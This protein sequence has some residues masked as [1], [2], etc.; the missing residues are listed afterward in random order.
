MAACVRNHAQSWSSGSGLL[1]G[2]RINFCCFWSP[3]HPPPV[4]VCYGG[5]GESCRGEL[6]D[7]TSLQIAPGLSLCREPGLLTMLPR[8]VQA[9]RF[10]FVALTVGRP[11]EWILG[12]SSGD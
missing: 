1:N 7:H 10:V 3:P 4:V 2:G 5:H 8:S 9:S 11:G 6:T 12:V